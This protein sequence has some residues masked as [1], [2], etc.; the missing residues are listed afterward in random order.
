MSAIPSVDFLPKLKDLSISV[1]CLGEW[2]PLLETERPSLTKLHLNCSHLG[3]PGA[4]SFYWRDLPTL[5]PNLEDLYL[6]RNKGLT[7]DT[8]RH[9]IIPRLPH[10]KKL[11]IRV[12]SVELEP[13]E[14]EKE[15]AEQ[16]KAEIKIRFPQVQIEFCSTP[17]KPC[18]FMPQAMNHE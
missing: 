12:P 16:F 9:Q 7:M 1:N 4:S 18:I 17:G 3:I 2:S 11:S 15:M 10:L 13:S 5:W 6:G 8:L 14:K